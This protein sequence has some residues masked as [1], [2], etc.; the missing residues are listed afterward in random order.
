MGLDIDGGKF[1]RELS[2]TCGPSLAQATCDPSLAQLNDLG[3]TSATG[4][5][6]TG[7]NPI[8]FF[9]DPLS[10]HQH[11]ADIE[12]LT[13]ICDVHNV[14]YATNSASG[15]GLVYA[16][17]SLGLDLGMSSVES[18]TVKEYKAEQAEV[19][20]RASMVSV[21]VEELVEEKKED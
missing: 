11:A 7:G 19:I 8:F 14:P 5:W 20:R 10:S 6:A 9:K 17:A 16:L 13:R 12:A 4:S 3:Q 1:W 18:D 2:S 21:S 15:K